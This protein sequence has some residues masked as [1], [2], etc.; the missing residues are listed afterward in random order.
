[1]RRKIYL[2]NSI[3]LL[4]HCC[5]VEIMENQIIV[6]GVKRKKIVKPFLMNAESIRKNYKFRIS[7]V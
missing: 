4:K 5:L 6:M 2:I 1:M 7:I 3:V